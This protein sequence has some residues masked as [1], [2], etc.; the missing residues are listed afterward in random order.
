MKSLREALSR[1]EKT[2]GANAAGVDGL[3]STFRSASS[4]FETLMTNYKA[5]NGR[6]EA[7]YQ[8]LRGLGSRIKAL[9][10]K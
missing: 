5:L 3:S 2:V 9:E 1:L 6:I 4:A 8:Q 7:N 10:T